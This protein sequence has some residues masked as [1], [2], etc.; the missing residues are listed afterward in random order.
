MDQATSL[1]FGVMGS[2]YESELTTSL[3]RLVA[4]ALDSGHRVTVWTC[5]GATTLTRVALGDHKPKNLL[6][7][8]GGFPDRTYAST[9]ALVRALAE[10]SEGRLQWYVCRHCAEERGALD[11]IAEARVQP[12]MRFVQHLERCDFP[13]IMGVK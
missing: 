11:Q 6:D 1:F 12:P 3:L 7:V 9:A 4:A 10:R 5:G 2:P 13:V 8:L